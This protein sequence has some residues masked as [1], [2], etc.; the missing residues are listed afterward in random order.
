MG[1]SSETEIRNRVGVPPYVI[2]GGGPVIVL[3]TPHAIADGV[4]I[5]VGGGTPH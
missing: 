2:K 1:S 5:Q 4:S 3:K